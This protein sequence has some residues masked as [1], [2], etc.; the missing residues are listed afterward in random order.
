MGESRFSSCLESI[1]WE[2]YIADVAQKSV[3]G[4]H[5]SGYSEG[6]GD[7][8]CYRGALWA[9]TVSLIALMKRILF[10]R[11]EDTATR[12]TEQLWSLS[13][14]HYPGTG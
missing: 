6:P 3:L 7:R 11:G 13:D 14:I 4:S 8:W 12:V 5:H 9:A 10:I 1:K 2:S